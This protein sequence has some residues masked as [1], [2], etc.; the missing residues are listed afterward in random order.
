MHKKYVLLIY[1]AHFFYVSYLVATASKRA[2]CCAEYVLNG[3]I[4]KL[5]QLFLNLKY[6]LDDDDDDDNDDEDID[7]NKND[8]DDDD[9]DDNDKGKYIERYKRSNLNK[10]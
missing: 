7:D 2:F 4:Y 8:D 9:D 3:Y 6:F 1:F 5:Q 10:V